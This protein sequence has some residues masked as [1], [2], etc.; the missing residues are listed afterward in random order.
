ME[1]NNI[2]KEEEE[3]QIQTAKRVSEGGSWNR[4]D[5][6]NEQV[7]SSKRRGRGSAQT[8]Q[9]LGNNDDNA[10]SR[11]IISNEAGSSLDELLARVND[12]FEAGKVSR[13]QLVSWILRRFAE[14]CGESEIK[15][16]RAAH[17]DRIA[18]LEALLKRAKET[19][20]LPEELSALLPD[21]S[22]SSKKAK[23]S[24]KNNI[25]GDIINGDAA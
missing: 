17:F 5:G 20:T 10:I 1:N 2:K 11:V 7:Q 8:T 12:Q 9:S 19:G 16:I 6:E 3:K 25:N 24:L 18:Y 22:I 15:E 13:P 14:A 21:A 23:K 4:E